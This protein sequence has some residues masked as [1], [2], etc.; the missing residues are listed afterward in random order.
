MIGF[1]W[2]T[3]ASLGTIIKYTKGCI[4][5]TRKLRTDTKDITGMKFGDLTALYINGKGKCRGSTWRCKCDCGN[6]CDAYGG[7]LREGTRK[8]CGCLSEKRVLETG[9]N[10][11]MSFYRRKAKKRGI[12]F[13]LSR[14]EF[15]SL[16][17][18][19]CFYC[20]TAPENILLRQKSKKLQIVYTGIDRIDSSKAYIK[21][22]CV[23]ACFMCNRSKSNTPLDQW[24]LYLKKLFSHQRITNG[25]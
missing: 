16:I 10:K 20:G 21:Q 2:F 23:P 6:E 19:N 12:Q 25:V 1:L 5:R 14:E 18:E 4:M 8:S 15:K 3:Y 13:N 9:I 11:I 24:L 7:H 17:V 22:N